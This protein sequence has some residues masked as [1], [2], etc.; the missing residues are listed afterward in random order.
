MEDN[1]D[2]DLLREW[3]TVINFPFLPLKTFMVQQNLQSWFLDMSPPS[4]LVAGLLNKANFPFQPTLV[5]WVLAF[6]WRAVKPEFG[7]IYC[8]LSLTYFYTSPTSIS[9]GGKKVPIYVVI[10]SELFIYLYIFLPQRFCKHYQGG[11]KFP[12]LFQILLAG[13]R[14]KLKETG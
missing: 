9:L 2:S 6:K 10:I 11:R 13:L 7:N 3:L 5:S 8:K 4:P 12:L 1:E 14:I